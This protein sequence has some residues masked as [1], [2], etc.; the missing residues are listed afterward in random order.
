M[1]LPGMSVARRG[2]PAQSARFMDFRTVTALTALFL[3]PGSGAKAQPAADPLSIWTLQD[4]NASISAGHPTDRYYV[5]GLRLGGNSPPGR[6]PNFLADPG[7]TR[8]GG[9]QQRIAF[10][11]AQQIYMPV[12]TAAVVPSPYDRP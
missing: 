9:G 3:L 1:T 4:E 8:W 12:D 2:P 5:N 7:N 10:V 11:L 6:V